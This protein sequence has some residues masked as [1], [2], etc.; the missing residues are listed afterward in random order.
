MSSQTNETTGPAK[1]I[2]NRIP[3]SQIPERDSTGKNKKE[4]KR[5]GEHRVLPCWFFFSWV[6]I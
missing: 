6:V 5:R 1:Y 2:S 4:E 3:F